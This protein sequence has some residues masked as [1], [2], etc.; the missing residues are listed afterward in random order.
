LPDPF[1]SRQDLTDYLGADVNSDA[2]ALIA[3]D[4]ACDIVRTLTEQD[5]NAL[6]ETIKL[7]GTGTDTLL[8][9]QCPVNSAGTVVVNG[10]TLD[11][12]LDYTSTE[13]GYLI[14][15][16]GTAILSTW[17]RSSGPVGYWPPGRQNVSVTYNHGYAGTVPSD[18]RAVALMIASRM[19]VQGV[20]V[21]RQVG[22]ANVKYAG[23]ATDLNANELRICRKYKRAL[24]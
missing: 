4:A 13:D 24:S 12:T 17:S 2:G 5:F 1:I 21:Q 18:I 7:D 10:G 8:L 16:D 14:R 19:T 11:A 23:P 22:A 9:P 3:V 15:T 6:T 20:D